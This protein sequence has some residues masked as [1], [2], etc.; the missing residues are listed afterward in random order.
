MR[1]EWRWSDAIDH[2]PNVVLTLPSTQPSYWQIS[3]ALETQHGL[4]L[5]FGYCGNGA[6]V[7]FGMH[8]IGHGRLE[9]IEPE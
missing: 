2:A 5:R 3:E 4:R 9:P 1:D 8:P 6:S 7:L